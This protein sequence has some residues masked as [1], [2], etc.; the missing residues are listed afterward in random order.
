MASRA[1]RTLLLLQCLHLQLISSQYSGGRP[2]QPEGREVFTLPPPGDP[3]YRTYIYNNRRYGQALPPREFIPSYNNPQLPNP[4]SYDPTINR[5]LPPGED[6]NRYMFNHELGQLIPL[7]GVLGKWRPDLQGKQRDNWQSLERDVIVDTKY[8]KVQGFKTYL[9][10]NPDPKSGY[11]PGQTGQ[12]ERIQGKVDVFLGIPYAVPPIKEGRFRPPRPHRGWEVIQAVDFGPACPQPTRFT[13]ATKGIRD[14]DEDCLYLNVYSPTTVSGLAKQ[15]PVMFYIHGGEFSKGASNLFPGHVLAAFYE[16]VVVTINYRLGALGFLSTADANSP[17]NYGIQDMSMALRWVYENIQFFNGDR[18]GITVFGPDA[19]AAAAGLLMVNPRSRDVIARVIAQSGSAT[20]DWALTVDRYRAQNTSRVYA[21]R[22]GCGIESSYKLVECLRHRSFYE[23]GN[24]EFEPQVGMFPWGPVLDLNFTVP[25]D[26]WYEGW[27]EQDWRFTNFTAEQYIRQG[28]F[29]RGLSYMTGVTTQ[30]AAF[31]IYNNDSLAPLYEVDERFFDQKIKE[32]VLRYN[33]TLNQ[34]GIYEAIKYM[35]TY[36]PD[37]TNKTHLREQYIHMLSDFW[38]RAPVDQIV[39][40]LV[41]Q[42]VPVYMYVLNTTI[43]AFR[44]PEWRKYPHDIEHYLLTGAPFMD[45]EFFPAKPRLERTMWTDNDRNMSH[46][47]M[48]AYSNFARFGNPTQ[49]QI[50]GLH[51]EMARDGLLKYLSVNTTFNS[52]V[53]LNYRQTE[54]AFW[55]W[56]LPTVVGYLVPTYP[57]STEYW[58]EPKEPLQIAFWSMSTVNLVLVVLIFIFCILWRNAK[59]ESLYYNGDMLMMSEGDRMEGIENNIQSHQ[60]STSNIYSMEYRDAPA[61]QPLPRRT[62]SNPSLRTGSNTSL[63]KE[64]SN[65]PA[66]PRKKTTPVAAKRSIT[67]VDK[68]GVPQ[69]DV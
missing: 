32:L 34:K 21:M 23:L 54:S 64:V 2:I 13:G 46:F 36:W 22:L 3:N 11:R 43:E 56:Y 27:R 44:F 65:S 48:K 6:P 58:W 5:G 38:Y 12:V 18:D 53:Q 8:G 42:H 40:L 29:N 61:K 33:Y 63:S 16:V 49:T 67:K 15:Y 51:F 52:S 35:Y 20:A 68:V 39:K 28:R 57:P 47:F 41:E 30:E 50:L 4:N 19:G 66:G 69:T 59:R 62:P 37:P 24:A 25:R 17:G 31:V 7:P 9:Y 45:I 1:S 55:T 26:T 14:M 60:R 10:D